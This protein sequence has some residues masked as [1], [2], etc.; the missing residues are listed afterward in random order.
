MKDDALD[1]LAGLS[2][3]LGAGLGDDSTTPEEYGRRIRWGIDHIGTVYRQRAA[4]VVEECSTIRPLPT[5]GYVKRAILDD[6]ALPTA[7]SLIHPNQ[8]HTGE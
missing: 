3:F 6:T 7:M 8:T 2:S 5:W 4:Q 1:I